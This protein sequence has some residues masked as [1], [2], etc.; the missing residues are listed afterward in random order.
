VLDDATTMGVD[1]AEVTAD[2]AADVRAA[3]VMAAEGVGVEE[4]AATSRAGV[5]T[6]EAMIIDEAAEVL[7]RIAAVVVAVVLPDPEPQVATAPP[8]AV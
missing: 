2:S 5:A 1:A 7:E 6:D 8:G 4:T 3:D